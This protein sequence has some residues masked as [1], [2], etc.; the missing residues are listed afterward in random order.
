MKKATTILALA[1]MA[2]MT[3][4]EAA[5]KMKA[6]IIDGQN[7]HGIWPKTTVMMKSYLEKSGLFTVD[8]AR[9]AFTWQGDKLI[10]QYPVKLDHETQALPKPKSDPN[11]TPTFS[12]YDLVVSNFGWNAAPWPDATKAALEA[13][14]NDGGGLAVVHAAD[15]SFAEWHEYNRM[16]GLGGWGDRN[17]K[18][19]PYVYYDDHGHL[20]R[21]TSPGRGGSHGKQHNYLVETRDAD[22][23]ITKG[24]PK[25]WLHAQD[26]LYDR[27]RGP[28]ENMNVLAT[29]FSDKETGGTGRHEPMLITIE[30]GQGRVYH[31]PMGHADYSMECVGFITTF[32]RGAEWAATGK[33]TLTEVP[34]DF[35]SPTEV[36]Q[37]KFD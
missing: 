35:P 27:L 4:L 22:H 37:R 34:E 16:I 28:A 1:G 25:K 23:P 29:A 36:K 30:Y 17:E 9:T 19:G 14:V 5:D 3:N 13:Y 20:V 21:D 33:V 7:N 11:F 26:E 6:L 24:L 31:T 8:V 12:D 18:S 10:P 32:V 15:N 2:L